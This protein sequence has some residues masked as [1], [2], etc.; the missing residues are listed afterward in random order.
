MSKRIKEGLNKW[1]DRPYSKLRINGE[2][3]ADDKEIKR[4]R[5]KWRESRKR[6]KASQAQ[7]N[8]EAL[9]YQYTCCLRLKYPL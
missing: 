5:G 2:T 8:L 9:P 7:A 6:S 1:R 4:E 3:M